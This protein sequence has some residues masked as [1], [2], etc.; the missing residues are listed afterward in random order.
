MKRKFGFHERS[1]CP[2]ANTLDLA[3]D[4]WS[5][6]IVRDMVNG[7]RKFGEFLDS[8]ERIPTNILAE[9]LRR[10]E[11]AGL[12]KK[13]PYQRLPTRYAYALTA[14]GRGL[15]PVLQAIC[16]WGNA[17]IPKTWTPPESFM[18]LRP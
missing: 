12:V 13:S 11:A 7:K 8:P 9:R 18:R 2:I 17:H 15:I 5:L 10:L 1:G 3:G 16:R 14:K 6:L 4:K